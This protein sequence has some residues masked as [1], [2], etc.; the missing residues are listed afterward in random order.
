MKRSE[1][2]HHNFNIGD[3]VQDKRVPQ[4]IGIVIEL[5]DEREFN[6]FSR[7]TKTPFKV[8]WCGSDPKW[9]PTW[10]SPEEM[11]LLSPAQKSSSKSTNRK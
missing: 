4:W 5:D 8:Q 2:K 6:L 10:E 3:L 7:R 9:E 11:V 1:N